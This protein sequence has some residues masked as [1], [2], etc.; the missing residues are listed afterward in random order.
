MNKNLIQTAFIV[1]LSVSLMSCATKFNTANDDLIEYTFEPGEYKGKPALK[2]SLTFK[3]VSGAMTLLLPSEWAGNVYKDDISELQILTPGV[4]LSQ[5]EAPEEMV[6]NQIAKENR[7]TV[8]YHILQTADKLGRTYKNMIHQEYFHF[9]G[10]G[11]LVIPQLNNEQRRDVSMH[12]KNFPQQY[13]IVN[14]FG[15]GKSR[16]SFKASLQELRDSIYVGG[17]YRISETQ[18]KNSPLYVAIRG[19]WTFKDAELDE[20]ASSIVEYQRNFFDDHTFKTFLITVTPN[21]EVC[22]STGGTGL[23]NSFATFVPNDFKLDANAKMLLSHELFHTWNGRKIHREEPEQLVYWFSEGFTDYYSRILLLRS[24]KLTIPEFLEDYNRETLYNY[25]TSSKINASNQKILKDFWNNYEI[26][27]LPYQRGAILAFKWNQMIKNSTQGKH[28]LDDVFR[29]LFKESQ[30]VGTVVSSKNINRLT[31]KYLSK[32]ISADLK[33]FI[34][35][36]GTII[37]GNYDLGPCVQ[38]KK[39]KMGKFE[40][41][42][43]SKLTYKNNIISGVKKGSNA[44]RA[45]LRDG[46]KLVHRKMVNPP[47]AESELIIHDGKIERSIK[48]FPE[49][50][51]KYVTYR[52]ILDEAMYKK[53]PQN[54][55]KGF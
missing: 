36:G 37:P 32:G 50:K 1:F 3:A 35:E 2:V 22:C 12:W 34:E 21:G 15:L 52:Y 20:L 10:N 23:T 39:E 6:I 40:H 13:K 42:Y 53:D 5:G 48:Y 9:I 41:G 33:S 24:G 26:E 8:S 38:L 16:Q 11:A 30:T 47:Y 55:L 31:Q 45:G 19:E 46:F 25:Y 4:N 49:S 18:I 43:D 17:D 29:D 28:S 54:C 7:I 44:Y 14:S 51:K 27:K